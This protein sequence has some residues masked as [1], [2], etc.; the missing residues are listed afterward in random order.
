ME[1][2]LHT[3][4]LRDDVELLVDMKVESTLEINV[5]S[6]SCINVVSTL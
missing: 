6:T 4:Q 2:V 5:G 3:D 1:Y